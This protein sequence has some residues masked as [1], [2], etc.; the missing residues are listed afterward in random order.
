MRKSL[1]YGLLHAMHAFVQVVE[2]GSFTGAAEHMALS[3]GQVRR[4]VTELENR[5]QTK[6]LKRT[7]RRL[8]LTSAGERYVSQCRTILALVSDAESEASGARIQA[9]G[10]LRVLC[11]TSF[12][13]RYVMPLITRYCAL[14]P[15][16]S[17]EYSASQYVPD[18]L[19]EG[20][21]VSVYLA[22]RMPDSNLAAE[23]LGAVYSVLCAAPEYLEKHE[24][25]QCVAALSGHACLRLVNPSATQHWELTDGNTTHV[26]EPAGQLSADH[27]EAVLQ[28]ARAGQGI[29]M[30]PGFLALEALERGELVRVL[31]QWRSPDVDVYVLVPSREF[32]EAKT[33]AW[34]E[35]LRAELPIALQRDIERLYA[36]AKS[37]EPKRQARRAAKQR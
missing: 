13:D 4:V 7:T 9:T 16:V 18:L 35:L 37:A 2:A 23:R 6:L 26:F 24:S 32:L 28:A 31:P 33:V 1:D 20:L 29:A 3:M 27:P 22:R 36:G 12:G 15:A 19:A 8:T 34:V 17:V 11:M 10:R 30:L 25:P 14:N 21:D 5:L